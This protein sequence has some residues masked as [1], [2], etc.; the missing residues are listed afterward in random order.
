[1]W[2]MNRHRDQQTWQGALKMF[3]GSWWLHEITFSVA[4]SLIFQGVFVGTTDKI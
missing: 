2:G 3:E 1:M 4:F